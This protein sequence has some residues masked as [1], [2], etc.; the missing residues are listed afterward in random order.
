MKKVTARLI[1]VAVSV[2]L[3]FVGV[4]RAGGT[5]LSEHFDANTN[6]PA[7]WATTNGAYWVVSTPSF[8]GVAA[9]SGSNVALFNSFS[10]YSGSAALLSTPTLDFTGYSSVSFSFWM[11]HDTA[12]ENNLDT[13]MP[14][15]STDG[16]SSWSDLSATAINRYGGTNQWEQ[17]AFNL[18]SY[19]GDANVKLGFNATSAYGNNMFIDDVSVTTNGA[20]A[21]EPAALS[22]VFLGLAALLLRRR[23]A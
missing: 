10:L 19:I 4:A 23:R 7:G 1:V 15:I 6:W 12:W 5:L 17:V 8:P 9:H 18:A 20:S 22:L 14:Q 16:G 3:G 11:Y 21:P 2:L 13:I